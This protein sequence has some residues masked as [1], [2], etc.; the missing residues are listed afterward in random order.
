MIAHPDRTYLT[1]DD[2]LTHEANSPIK[3]EYHDG[4]IFAMAGASD[5]H[6]TI[7][8]NLTALLLPIAR[9]Q[10]CRVY[11]NL[12]LIQHPAPRRDKLI[13]PPK[14]TVANQLMRRRLRTTRLIFLT[15]TQ[16]RPLVM[17]RRTPRRDRLRPCVHL[18]KPLIHPIQPIY[19]IRRQ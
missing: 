17:H 19:L 18:R 15:Q 6:A 7:A 14:L 10:G 9:Q 5:E 11:S 16:R 1:P 8:A 3:H 4:E 13:R 2:Y 12:R